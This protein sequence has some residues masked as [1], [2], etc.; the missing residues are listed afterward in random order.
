MTELAYALSLGS[1][2]G[3]R[4]ENL[5]QAVQSLEEFGHHIHTSRIYK[6]APM[7]ISEQPMFLNMALTFV[8]F[9]AP[10]SL[11]RCLKT[12]E[13]QLGRPEGIRHG[14]RVVDIDIILC[15]DLM[16]N[17]EGL[18]V[19]H[20]FF[21][22]RDFV[23]RPLAEIA[24]DWIDPRSGASIAELGAMMRSDEV[25]LYNSVEKEGSEQ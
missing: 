10:L 6:T 15:A 13:Q 18:T 17:I 23:L 14:P 5:W 4:A 1:N 20:Q 7:Y 12:L 24:G 9:H 25:Q 22:E 2:L 19:P 3:N 16:I 8:S 11:L 21:Y